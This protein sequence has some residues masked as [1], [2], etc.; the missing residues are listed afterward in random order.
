MKK[1]LPYFKL[2][3]PVKGHFALAILFGLISGA[4]SG[5]GLPLLVSEIFPL[6][7]RSKETGVTSEAPQWLLSSVGFFG[8]DLPTSSQLILASCLSLPVI[9]IIR[10]VSGYFNTYYTNYTGLY[11]LEELRIMTFDKLQRLPLAFHKR[12]KVGDIQSR[13]M[14]D[15]GTIQTV[16]IKVSS[17]L[18]IEP[19]TLI[20]AV[21][22]LITLSLKNDG[23]M[24]ILGAIVSIPLCV[25]PIR[26]L[27]KKLLYRARLTRA[28]SGDMS[29]T[30]IENLSS[31]QEVRA[32]SMEDSQV[33]KFRVDS[34]E[35]RSLKLKT[36]KYQ[37]LV[38]P[39]VEIMSVVGI[40]LAI[41]LGAQRGLTL[42]VFIPIIM[43]MYFAYEPVKKLGAISASLRKAEASLERVEY[44]LNAKDSMPEAS[45]PTVLENVEGHVKFE[46]VDFA[47]DD[48][49]VLHSIDLEFSCWR[50]SSSSWAKWCRKVYLH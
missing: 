47:Y 36:I 34:T 24:I 35:I 12:H 37:Y 21:V 31:Q 28:K 19:V 33:G 15:T 14:S 1:F 16:L 30:V 8:V 46:Q 25:F 43:A 49:P 6:I 27:G 13:V 41:Y 2:L 26:Y 42:E 11:V 48:D 5:L 50:S 4:A 22:A 9:F 45:N 23:A 32:Y 3:K 18:I 17:R 7:F 38:S 40:S 44:V 39:S 20:A 29:A 10:G